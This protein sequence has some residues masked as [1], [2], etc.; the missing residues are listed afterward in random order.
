MR[1]KMRPLRPEQSERLEPSSTTAWTWFWV[2][3]WR[4]DLQRKVAQPFGPV[5]TDHF[6]QS[7]VL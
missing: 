2:T 6:N 3:R 4:L 7:Q 5:A 1:L